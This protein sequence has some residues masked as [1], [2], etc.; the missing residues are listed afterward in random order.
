MPELDAKKSVTLDFHVDDLRFNHR[1][2]MILGRD[3]LSELKLDL[4]LSDNTI[5][6]NVG[7]YKVCTFPM[8]YFSKINLAIQRIAIT[9]IEPNI[10]YILCLIIWNGIRTHLSQHTIRIHHHVS[11]LTQVRR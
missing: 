4:C 11:S 2:D 1:Y 6:I 9:D 5:R 3:M 10:E 8:K 7:T